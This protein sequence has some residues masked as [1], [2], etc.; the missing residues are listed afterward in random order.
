[1]F[2]LFRCM[3][4][5]SHRVSCCF[6]HSIEVEYR[7]LDKHFLASNFV[8]GISSKIQLFRHFHMHHIM[9]MII[10]ID[11]DLYISVVILAT[12]QWGLDVLGGVTSTICQHLRAK[13]H[14]KKRWDQISSL[15]LM[16]FSHVYES[17]TPLMLSFS[18]RS[19]Q[20]KS[21]FCFGCTLFSIEE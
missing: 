18:C 15:C 16:Q 1:M 17:S 9:V 2:R 12:A 11:Q 5:C 13:L 10:S 3:H 6:F 19:S 8:G 21:L 14:L 4:S 20:E 7:L